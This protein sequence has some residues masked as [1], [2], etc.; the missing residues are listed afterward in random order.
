MRR[1][2]RLTVQGPV[3]EHQ[4]D[5]MSHR[6]GGGPLSTK[7]YFVLRTALRDRPPNAAMSQPTASGNDQPAAVDGGWPP[8]VGSDRLMSV[9]RFADRCGLAHWW[10]AASLLRFCHVQ[11]HARPFRFGAPDPRDKGSGD[12]LLCSN[13][14]NLT[15]ALLAGHH[16]QVQRVH[17]TSYKPEELLD[18][19]MARLGDGY[20]ALIQKKALEFLAKKVAAQSGVPR[21][22]PFFG[23]GDGHDM[24]HSIRST[25]T[26]AQSPS[27]SAIHSPAH[28]GPSYPPPRRLYWLL[29]VFFDSLRF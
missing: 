6:G 2:E 17:F 24:G 20:E 27:C 8:T 29:A 19:T 26:V 21:V 28:S 3:K 13:D 14:M 23:T 5:G 16:K 18:I 22:T 4:R 1:E 15:D 12:C 10:T 7:V 11:I 25:C 9:K